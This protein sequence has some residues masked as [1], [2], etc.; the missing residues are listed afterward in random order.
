MA[1]RVGAGDTER[2]PIEGFIADI[3]LLD[4]GVI[5]DVQETQAPVMGPDP[6][7]AEGFPIFG[8]GVVDNDI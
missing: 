6:G 3:D 7:E 5:T 4:D 1:L 2:T 8:G